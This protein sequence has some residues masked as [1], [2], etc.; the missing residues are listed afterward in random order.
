LGGSV[1][2]IKENAEALVK[3]NSKTGLEV[4]ADK[5]KYM[6]MSRDQNVKRN[7]SI[8]TENRYFERMKDLKYLGTNLTYQDSIQEEIESRVKSGNVCYHSV[9]NFLS[10]SLLST[11]LK[12][13][14]CRN[15]ILPVGA[16]GYETWSLILREKHRLRVSENRVLR[17][18]FRPKRDEATREWRKL[19][20]EELND[21]YSSPNI[22]WVIKSRKI[23]WT[24]HVARMGEV[25]HIQGFGGET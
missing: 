24:G 18:I 1:H 25:R 10:Y 7:H 21:P 20:N 4:N 23:K 14:I 12:I 6:F 2:T 3:A 11:N 5:T 8:K 17:R 13:K 19:H 16:C 9:Q 22:V 15:I